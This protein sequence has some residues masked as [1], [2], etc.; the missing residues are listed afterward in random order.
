MSNNTKS[1]SSGKLKAAQY[2]RMSTEH[3]QYSTENQR[4]TIRDYAL[5]NGMDIICTYSDE[6]KSGLTIESRD[7]LKRLIRDVQSKMAKFSVILVY[8]ISRWGRFQNP[9]QAAFLEYSCKQEGIT[10][11]YCAE[12]FQNDG[13]MF[14]SIVKTVKRAMAGEYSRELSA[15][16]FKGQCKLIELGFRQGGPAGYGLQRMRIDQNGNHIDILRNGEYKS[17]QTDRV[18]LV[19]GPEQ[20]VLVV[21]K[22]YSMFVYENKNENEIS[23]ILNTANVDSEKERPWTKGAVHQ[24]LTNEKY[25]G[26]NVFNR[27]SFKLKQKRVKNPPDTWIRNNKAFTPIVTEELFSAAQT[28]ILNRSKKLTN[29]EILDMLRTLFNTH[30][31]I[32]GILIDE[33]DS[34]PSSSVYRT[35][36]GSLLRAYKLIGYTPERNYK[37]IEDNKIIRT[38]HRDLYEK[39]ILRI[40][41]FNVETE[42]NNDD[43]IIVNSEICLCI[44]LARCRV[45]TSGTLR[46]LIKFEHNNNSDIILCAR[47]DETNSSILDYYIFPTLDLTTP[48]LKLSIDNQFSLDVYRH[49]SIEYLLSMF[50]RSKILSTA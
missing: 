31:K 23:E 33:T 32:S 22:I 48:N 10:V 36:F 9:D 43:Q 12:I 18:I 24:I 1:N 21:N 39:I 38:I 30:G 25:I 7:G 26:N 29:D 27:T 37:F 40:H 46:W 45:L 34:M 16:V 49:A 41:N 5:A 11:H 6:G 2:V 44:I 47:L 28:I 14:S 8:D 35:R 17:L 42:S 20:E 15:K 4:D 3:Q 13:S 19:P 50:K